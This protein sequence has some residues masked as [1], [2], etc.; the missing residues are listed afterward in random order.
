M[1]D[2]PSPLAAIAWVALKIALDI[3]AQQLGLGR[4][5]WLEERVSG[6]EQ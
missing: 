1:A 6:S 2:F 4:H 5:K 3:Y